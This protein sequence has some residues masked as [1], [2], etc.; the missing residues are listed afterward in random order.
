MRTIGARQMLALLL[1]LTMLLGAAAMGG[2]AAFAAEIQN[3]PTDQA[4][5]DGQLALIKSRFASLKQPDGENPWYYSVT[6]LDHNGRLELIAASQ[7]PQSRATNLHIWEV[8][9]DRSTLME[10]GLAKD[11]E[12]SFPDILTD[13]ADTYFSASAS[14]WHYLFYDHVVLSDTE[15]YTVKTAVTFKDGKIDYESYAVEHTVAADGRRDVTHTDANGAAISADQYN[16]AGHDAMAGCARSSTNFEW[17]TADKAD[18]LTKLSDSFQVF[19]GRKAPSEDFPVP[20][21]AALSAASASPAPQPQLYLTITKNPTN[22]NHTEGETALFV[23]AASA[24]ESLN[25]TFV[26]PNGREYTAESV[27]SVWGTVSGQNSTTLSVANVTTVMNGWG[28]YCTFNYR[29]QTARTATAWLYVSA[30]KAPPAGNYDGTV[31]DFSYSS[32][33]INV[34]NTVSTTVSRD[35]C[36][37]DGELYVGAYA[38]L[39]WDGQNVTYCRIIGSQPTPGSMSGN[40]YEGGGGF[41]IDLAN[42]DQI[43]AD[44]WLCSVSGTFYNGA[45][46]D[47]YYN[48]YPIADNISH[49]DIYGSD[50]PPVPVVGVMYCPHCGAELPVVQ[51]DNCPY[52]GYPLWGDGGDDPGEFIGG[53]Y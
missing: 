9:A 24:Y 44:A 36:D 14:A 42:G 53:V 19:M 29:G 46:C 49:V 21:P 4:D 50:D 20:Q 40:A 33:T 30:R 8:S 7:H 10:C 13:A 35:I 47:V 22:E 6:D 17:L 26:A 23:A 25:W 48:D 16:A 37:I 15:V 27:Q 28:V 41:A 34:E 3:A 45:P 1:M 11:P 39:Y 52:C 51:M 18:D 2:A 31:T 38:S 5:E 43:Y 12:E 32:V